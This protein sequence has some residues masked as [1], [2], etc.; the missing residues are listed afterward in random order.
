MTLPAAQEDS[1]LSYSNVYT[2]VALYQRCSVGADVDMARSYLI[3]WAAKESQSLP[4]W[5]ERDL[6][7]KEMFRGLP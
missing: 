4:A 3:R 6:T 2:H 1:A 7:S 5:R